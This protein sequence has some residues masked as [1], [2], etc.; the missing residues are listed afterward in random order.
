[1]PW[2]D[3]LSNQMVSF[4][5]AQGGGFTLKA[6]QSN[7]NSLQ[8][9]TKAEAL[10]KYNLVTA[11]MDAYTNTQLVPKIAWVPSNCILSIGSG[12]NSIVEVIYPLSANGRVL[13]GG[14]F[15]NYKGNTPPAKMVCLTQCGDVDTTFNTGGIGFSSSSFSIFA[16]RELSDGKILVGG[17]FTQYNGVTANYLLRLNSN[18]TLDTTFN[19]G[20]VG[21][22]FWIMDISIQSDNK[23]IITGRLFNYNNLTA[24]CI[25]R[26]NADGTRDT[27]FVIGSGF[28]GAVD[29]S[30]IQSDGKIVA[31]GRFTSYNGTACNNIVRLL[32]NGSI[33][34]TFI[35]GVGFGGGPSVAPN[36][37]PRSVKQQSDGKLIIA[38]AFSTYKTISSKNIIRLNSDGSIDNSFIVGVGFDNLDPNINQVNDTLIDVNGS[39]VVVGKFTSYNGTARNNIVRLLNNGSIDNSFIVGSGLMGTNMNIVQGSA[40]TQ[41]SVGNVWVGGFFT[42]YNNVPFGNIVRL[43]GNGTPN[44]VTT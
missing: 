9:M 7:V 28:N 37:G 17:Q 36:S 39:I 27:S 26:L 22:D 33:D 19:V 2:N 11:N 6:G 29:G 35:I 1:M 32:P 24:N 31:V 43:D 25:V 40:V 18:G 41:D 12:F 4:T 20:G 21:P 5:D 23:I 15:I 10:A 34:P 30:T 13:V 16:I 38:G 14:Q 42:T 8:C 44:I 3:L